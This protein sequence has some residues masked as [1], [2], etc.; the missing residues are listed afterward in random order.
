M[1]RLCA[2]AGFNL[3]PAN[4]AGLSV[5]WLQSCNSIQLRNA[6]APPERGL[7]KVDA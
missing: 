6:K 7:L 5:L 1:E 2:I 4:R 3:N